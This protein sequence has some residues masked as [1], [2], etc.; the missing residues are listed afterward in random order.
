MDDLC[1]GVFF[2]GVAQLGGGSQISVVLL[3]D[4]MVEYRF[5]FFG[6]RILFAFF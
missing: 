4:T 6:F 1:L 3:F 2:F 5:F